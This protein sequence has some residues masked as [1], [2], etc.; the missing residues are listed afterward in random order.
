M[1]D[2]Q[3]E[4][5]LDFQRASS[6]ADTLM[7]SATVEQHTPD[8]EEDAH[9]RTMLTEQARQQLI[10]QSGWEIYQHQR[11]NRALRREQLSLAMRHRFE[12]EAR[13]KFLTAKATLGSR[14]QGTSRL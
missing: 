12:E 10:A 4:N 6:V 13:E 8:T 2:P 1:V 14:M 3:L 5:L 7:D 9:L 11:T